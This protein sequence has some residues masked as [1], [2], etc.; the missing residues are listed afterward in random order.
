MHLRKAWHKLEVDDACLVGGRCCQLVALNLDLA[1]FVISLLLGGAGGEAL[2]VLLQEDQACIT[3]SFAC[4]A[5]LSIEVK[6]RW[7]HDDDFANIKAGELFH[8]GI[9]AALVSAL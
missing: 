9:A 3:S 6:K 5:C 2:V 7:V 1:P 8:D 4:T